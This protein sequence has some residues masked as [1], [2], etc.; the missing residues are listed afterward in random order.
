[1]QNDTNNLNRKDQL[2]GN[3]IN[4]TFLDDSLEL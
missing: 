4:I 3:Q 1:M 2:A